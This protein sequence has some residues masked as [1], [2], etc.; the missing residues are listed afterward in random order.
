M[1]RTLDLPARIA[2][3]VSVVKTILVKGSGAEA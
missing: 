2:A 3:T 1:A